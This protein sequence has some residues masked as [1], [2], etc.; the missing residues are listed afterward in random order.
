[1]L[2]PTSTTRRALALRHLGFEDLDALEPLLVRRGYAVETIDVPLHDNFAPLALSADLLIVLGGPIGVY[3]QE[4]F[5][6]L[7]TEIDVIRQRL[8]GGR[9]VLGICLGAQLMAAALEARV[10]PGTAGKEIGWKE[11]QLT[12][13]GMDSPLAALAKHQAVLHWHGDTFDLPEGAVL[14]AGTEQYPHQAFG[15]GDHGLALQF[16]VEASSRGLER[17]YVGHV[18]ELAQAEVPVSALRTAAQQHAPAVNAALAP[19]LD[20]YLQNNEPASA[21]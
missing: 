12:S 16:H 11:L 2:Q 21:V 3:Q 8:L 1:M 17:W 6:F 5:P 14:L 18:G 10:F 7:A 15:Y 4:D 13:A 9:T 19:I 20:A